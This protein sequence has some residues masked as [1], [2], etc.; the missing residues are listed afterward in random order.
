[1]V[2]SCVFILF[3]PLHSL[4][5]SPAFLLFDD[6]GMILFGHYS[7]IFQNFS[8]SEATPLIQITCSWAITSTVVIT[9]SKQSPYL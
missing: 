8:G 4:K 7:M 5:V 6:M 3:H 2:N 1:M 9:L